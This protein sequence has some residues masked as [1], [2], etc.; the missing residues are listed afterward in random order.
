M[1][2]EQK[3]K[4]TKILEVWEEQ[5]KILKDVTTEI[6]GKRKRN[7]KSWISRETWEKIEDRKQ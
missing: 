4:H 1:H 7:H 5:K 6:V 3:I 2:I